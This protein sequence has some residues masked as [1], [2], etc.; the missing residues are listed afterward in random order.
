VLVGSIH[1]NHKLLNPKTLAAWELQNV[2]LG[3]DSWVPGFLAHILKGW[4]CNEDIH[5]SDLCF[6][7]CS[8]RIVSI[9]VCRCLQNLRSVLTKFK[10]RHPVMSNTTSSKSPSF[11]L[12]K[13][14][15]SVVFYLH[16]T[17]ST[18]LTAR[19]QCSENSMG[20]L[21]LSDTFV[22][23]EVATIYELSRGLGWLFL[24][25]CCKLLEDF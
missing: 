6:K 8:L 24:R 19:Q 3:S 10:R 5:H 20:H 21:M 4:E 22:T 23:C 17:S 13:I 12:A 11:K 9:W 1:F 7:R 14:A 25:K 2:H 18:M 15:R 16:H